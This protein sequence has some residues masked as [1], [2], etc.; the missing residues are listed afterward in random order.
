MTSMNNNA[1]RRGPG[2]VNVSVV[3]KALNEAA[4]IERAVV[5]ALAAVAKVGGEVI[6]ADSR[7]DDDTV[8]IAARHPIRIVRLANVADRSC[9][10]GAQLGYQYSRG[11]FIY[12]MDGD[13]RM[14]EDF[15]RQAIRF[16]D[17]NPGA[18]GVGGLL[19]EQNLEAIEYASRASRAAQHL[20]S[21]EVSR[22]DGGGLYRRA[23]IDGVG[24]LTDRNLHSYE[25]IDLAAR[26][27]AAGWSLHRIPVHAVDHWG[28]KTNAIRLMLRRWKTRYLFGSGEVLR[29]AIGRP[30]FRIIARELR[31]LWIYAAVMAWFLL[32][33]LALIFD[34]VP[35]IVVLGMM[36][37]PWLAISWRK[38]SFVLGSYSIYGW[39]MN[40][41]ALL[42]GMMQPRKSPAQP[43]D[44]ELV[45]DQST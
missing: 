12:V 26:L 9:G 36:L 23:A 39:A 20:S 28:H 24:Y 45:R 34:R 17:E 40:V 35:G 15:L 30:H 42:I 27:R 7:S 4:H 44:S 13:M 1:E 32:I 3:I 2:D 33:V 18:G 11:R 22:L 6:L 10:V 41:P 37:L 31:E 43:I 16:M 38:R 25:E 29:A 19:V 14:D 21:G 8:Q 5:S